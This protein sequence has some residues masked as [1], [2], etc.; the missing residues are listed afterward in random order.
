M[1]TIKSIVAFDLETTGLP[2]TERNAPKITELAMVACERDHCIFEK[3]LP[4]VL[5]KLSVPVNPMKPVSYGA[6]RVSGKFF[7]IGI[8]AILYI[9]IN[10]K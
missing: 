8:L 4:R 9:S 5:P 7:L 6:Y 3:E 1:L 10:F 2:S